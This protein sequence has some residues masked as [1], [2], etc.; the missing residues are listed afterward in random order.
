MPCVLIVD[1]VASERLTLASLCQSLGFQTAIACGPA[2]ASFIIRDRRPQAAII[3]L[4]MPGADGLDCLFMFSKLA[5]RMPVAITTAADWLLLKAAAELAD[6][7]GLEH[8]V[9]IPKPV[10]VQSLR[11]F[12]NEARVPPLGAPEQRSR[13]TSQE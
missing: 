12:L 11:D 13:V 5:P 8:V 1:D 9:P 7:Y 6:Q 10:P 2:E 3:D 4:V